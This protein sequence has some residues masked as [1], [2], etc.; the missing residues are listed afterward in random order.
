MNRKV[1]Q[2]AI[3]VRNAEG[4]WV[5]E[6]EGLGRDSFHTTFNAAFTRLREDEEIVVRRWGVPFHRR[7]A[8][9]A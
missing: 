9:E 1:V 3:G 7:M 5:H 4:T 6:E 2:W 8:T